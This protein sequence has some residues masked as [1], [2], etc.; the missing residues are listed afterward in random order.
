MLGAAGFV[1]TAFST[2]VTTLF[3]TGYL[4]Y[5]LDYT[6][7]GYQYLPPLS[8]TVIEES[9]WKVFKV[10]LL[11][12]IFISLLPFIED[13]EWR[14]TIIIVFMLLLPFATAVLLIENSLIAATIPSNWLKILLAT[15][16][17]ISLIRLLCAELLL[18]VACYIASRQD[19]G[20]AGI[21]A[22]IFFALLMFR[23]LGV[24]LHTHASELGIHVTH[25]PEIDAANIARMR[26]R[27]IADEVQNLK[28]LS[29][30]VS[31]LKAFR[32]L[33][34]RL[35]QDHFQTE[36][37]FFD[38]LT[39]LQSP[40]L[41]LMAGQGYIERLVQKR[42]YTMA[43]DVLNFC[44]TASGGDYTLQRLRT[45]MTLATH[46]RTSEERL[47]VARLLADAHE[48]FPRDPRNGDA[49]VLSAKLYADELQLEEAETVL[50]K[51]GQS[52]PMW[53]QDPDYQKVR[54]LI[55]R[56]RPGS[57]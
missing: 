4:I 12:S 17:D 21:F 37:G 42:R 47:M 1:L 15:H 30:E 23:S 8:T 28:K 44:F 43:L 26:E 55:L 20:I 2:S 25:G 53:T 13:P 56:D 45:L 31:V 11:I 57:D 41:A 33:Q 29:E 35:A 22:I 50:K 16:L 32:Q 40:E 46:I 39:E 51:I 49:L 7:M 6:T 34:G 52:Y 18:L 27:D 36:T 38:H 9:R 54:E 19:T 3:F 10:M 14:T 5:V 24:M 48:H